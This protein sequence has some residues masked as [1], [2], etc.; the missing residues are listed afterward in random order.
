ML[1]C[2]AYQPSRR[3]RCLPPSQW[4]IHLTSCSVFNCRRTL[5]GSG[6]SANCQ[7][8]FSL[9]QISL[10]SPGAVLPS[11]P[12]RCSFPTNKRLCGI[13]KF[14]FSLWVFSKSLDTRFCGL[15]GG[16]KRSGNYICV[17]IL[18]GCNTWPVRQK[19]FVLQG[20]TSQVHDSVES[21]LG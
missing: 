1:I 8:N 7:V 12:C 14:R 20:G 17:E 5:S 18:W 11:E 15:R 9:F 13:F 19:N 6:F 4:P 21:W 10:K 16:K 3:L 2:Y